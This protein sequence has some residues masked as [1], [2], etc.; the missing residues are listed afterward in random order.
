MLVDA[1]I[2]GDTTKILTLVDATNVNQGRAMF[3]A[4]G[5]VNAVTPLW[6]AAWQGHLAAVK[7]LVANGATVEMRVRDTT[8][9]WIAA[10]SN[11]LTVAVFLAEHGAE[12]G[13]RA[14]MN[15]SAL[16]VAAWH[17]HVE[18]VAWLLAREVDIDA[19][20]GVFWRTPLWCAA[21][22]GH[23]GAVR[24]L[25]AAGADVNA[26]STRWCSTPLAAAAANDDVPVMRLLVG[27]A[28]PAKIDLG[29]PITIAARAG[30]FR[31]V[32]W[33]AALGADLG[34]ECNKPHCPL[35]FQPHLVLAHSSEQF[36]TA[37][38]ARVSAFL[39]DVVE[40]GLT[41]LE[42]A[43]GIGDEEIVATNLYNGVNICKILP[44]L[45]FA[46]QEQRWRLIGWDG[47]ASRMC[48]RT[49]AP[50]MAALLNAASLFWAPKRHNLFGKQLRRQVE[51]LLFCAA[52]L[53]I[54][55]EIAHLVCSFVTRAQIDCQNEEP[56]PGRLGAAV[57]CAIVGAMVGIAA[58]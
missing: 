49:P 13:T 41:D 19:S 17:G 40:C 54:P 27:R 42:I 52:R 44:T 57:I 37:R 20:D 47:V 35:H 32:E 3:N 34:P 56:W 16:W 1:A 2:V 12:I 6:G 51:T 9:F 18:I 7:L 46:D 25:V 30:A 21:H 45:A 31:A 36:E 43:I 48:L 26:S 28:N 23:R 11:N 39:R 50:S 5:T 4:D 22:N 24:A 38:H 10:A 14:A 8:P 58:M 53:S 15:R 29:S 55:V 33:L